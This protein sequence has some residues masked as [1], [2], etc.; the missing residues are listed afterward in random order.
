MWKKTRE[1]FIPEA[2]LRSNF[3]KLVHRVS[4]EIASTWE[5]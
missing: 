4:S 2:Q 1:Y 5:Q 3:K